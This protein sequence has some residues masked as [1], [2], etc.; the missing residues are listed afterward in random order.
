MTGGASGTGIGTVTYSVAANSGATRIGT[1]TIAGITY[2]VTQAGGGGCAYNLS[3]TSASVPAI[4]TT[5][6]AVSVVTGTSC[7][8]TATSNASWITVTGGAS[9][10]GIGT[11]TYSVAANSGSP[12]SGT[13]TIAGITYTVNQGAGGCSYSLSATSASVPAIG[14]TSGAVSV[15]TGT[16]CGWTA[17]SNASWITVT[18]GASG[19]GSGTVTYNA[20]ANP[21]ASSRTGTMTIAGITYTVTQAPS[22]LPSAP[23]HLRVIR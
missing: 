12:R 7:G 1:I 9:G 2:T 8:W 11:V 18:G 16:S 23:L 6:G 17:T 15:V 10:T 5:S 21:S 22:A 20:A 3:S 14:T 13:I 4:G 19:T